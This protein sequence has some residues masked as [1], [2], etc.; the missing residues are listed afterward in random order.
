MKGCFLLQRRFAPIGNEIAH[1]LKERHGVSSFCGYVYTRSSLAFL[2][3]QKDIDYTSLLLDEGIHESY[4]NEKLDWD[5]LRAF[6]KEYG[7]PN[8]WP[9]IDNERVVRYG[10]SVREYPHNTPLC[11]Y[12][13]ML[14]MVQVRAKKI[15]AFI[16][17]EKPDFMLFVAVAS[18]GSLLLYQI[19]KQKGIPTFVILSARVGHTH[20]ITEHY[21]LF[22]GVNWDEQ[23]LADNIARAKDF[24]KTFR[25]KPA[26]YT[27]IDSLKVKSPSR[28]RQLKFLTM[29]GMRS[30]IRLQWNLWHGHFTS[31]ERHDYTTI[32]PWH[33]VL[34]AV[35]RKIRVLYGFADLYDI[36]HPNDKYAF[37]PLQLEPETAMALYAPNFN[38]QLWVIRHIAKSL[39]VG[40]TLYVKEH[41]AMFGY[42]TRRFYKELKKIPNVKLISPSFTSFQLIEKA[43]I[44]TTITSTVGWEAL[45]LQKPVVTFGDVF[46]NQLPGSIQCKTPEELPHIIER[47]LTTPSLEED[48]LV[49]FIA[50]LYQEG[51][52]LDLV[53]MWEREAAV[54]VHERSKEL[55]PLTDLIFKKASGA[56]RKLD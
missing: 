14:R 44:I 30:S 16:D 13:D 22:T 48:V 51:A 1:L 26:P 46:Y 35:K 29:R 49:K 39:P 4:R 6:E 9:F 11:S 25:E 24:L 18:M 15:L 43:Q 28:T 17:T 37:F 33:F 5:F 34:D 42:R 52:P 38:D 19:A 7:M 21:S 45:C 53:N 55:I 40:Y 23:P 10:Q 36:P 20:L 27:D 8:L 3:N 54:H 41:L 50:R 32:K 12:E 56:K 47:Q 31:P 2:K